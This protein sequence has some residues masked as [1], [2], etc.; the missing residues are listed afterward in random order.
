MAGGTRTPND[1][2][3]RTR[4]SCE[5]GGDSTCTRKTAS[6]EIR[7]ALSRRGR[8]QVESLVRLPGTGT[9]MGLSRKFFCWKESLDVDNMVRHSSD[10]KTDLVMHLIILVL[11]LK[12][13]WQLA[14]DN[15]ILLLY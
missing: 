11:A 9:G 3:D 7:T 10:C 8:P 4:I 14:V 2:T 1:T 12:N 15:Q 6:A 5:C 13:D